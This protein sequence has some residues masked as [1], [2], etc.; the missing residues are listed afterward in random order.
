MTDG[1]S[2]TVHS[3][4]VRSFPGNSLLIGQP[5]QRRC[6]TLKRK[7]PTRYNPCKSSLLLPLS[8]EV[9]AD[10]PPVFFST[11]VAQRNEVDV[12]NRIS[13]LQGFGRY[14]ASNKKV[15]RWTLVGHFTPNAGTNRPPVHFVSSYYISMI[16]LHNAVA[17]LP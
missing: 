11:G 15:V 6:A 13:L 9:C 2:A 17:R 12:V 4:T 16:S 5:P 3:S 14:G 8:F 1:E 7:T 10:N